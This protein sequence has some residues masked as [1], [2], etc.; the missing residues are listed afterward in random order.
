MLPLEE[1]LRA[2][3]SVLGL[4]LADRQVGQLL[5]FAALLQKWTRVYNLTAVR[6]PGEVLTHHILDSA[7][8]LGPLGRMRLGAASRVL[9]VGSGGGLPGVVIA[10]A[11]PD[12]VIECVDAVAK[13]TAF[14]QQAA[15]SL[16]LPNLRAIHSR[17]EQLG[18]EAYNIVCSRAFA[19]LSDFVALSAGALASEGIWMAMKGKYP[20]DEVAALPPE[21]EV[22]HVEQLHV[23]G[24]NAD[25]CLLWL[26]RRSA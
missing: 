20:A 9:D 2:G 15:A 4:Q 23:P 6:D 1:E 21:V 24:M 17:V 14:I 26:R 8:V 5:E 19:T 18:G 12:L 3:L 22:F 10:I 7:A 16:Q 25:R 11:R 13:K